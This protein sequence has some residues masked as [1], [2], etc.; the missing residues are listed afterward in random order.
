MS[1]RKS[2]SER[3]RACPMVRSGFTPRPCYHAFNEPFFDPPLVSFPPWWG[4]IKTREPISNAILNAV[5][6]GMSAID[7]NAAGPPMQGPGGPGGLQPFGMLPPKTV[8]ATIDPSGVAVLRGVVKTI[9]ERIG[10]GQKLAKQPGVT[11]VINLLIVDPQGDPNEIPP[12]PP[13]PPIAEAPIAPSRPA[14]MLP[15][16]AERDKPA[17][18][19][20]GDPLAKRVSDAFA[21][22]PALE[23]LAI[24]VANRGGSITLTGKVPSRL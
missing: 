12:P 5:G 14:D 21:K 11:Q 4:A 17:L 1:R 6:N 3:R 22:R 16:D 23:G 2:R 19:V 15:N 10:V 18:F 8:E 7:P 20:D 24:K 13:T 9:E